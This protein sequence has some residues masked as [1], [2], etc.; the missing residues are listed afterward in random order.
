MKASYSLSHRASLHGW[1]TIEIILAL[2]LL[3]VVLH[4]VQQ[5]SDRQW[6]TLQQREETS[7]LRDNLNKQEVMTLLTGSKAWLDSDKSHQQG[8]YPSCEI[9]S[10]DDLTQWFN[11]AQGKVSSSVQTMV[12]DHD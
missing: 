11:A 7:R 9:C 10:G 6:Q 8:D 12:S 2:V 3:S 5:Q 4:L 1:I